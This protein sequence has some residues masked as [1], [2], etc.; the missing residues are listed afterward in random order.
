MIIKFLSFYFH[1]GVAV[2]EGKQ[3]LVAFVTTICYYLFG[4]LHHLHLVGC[5]QDLGP[6]VP[7][8]NV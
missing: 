2:G 6:V 5:D 4:V 8:G 7:S 3:S 1:L